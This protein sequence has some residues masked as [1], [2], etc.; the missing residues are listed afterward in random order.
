MTARHT[1]TGIGIDLTWH[2]FHAKPQPGAPVVIGLRPEHFAVNG[3][4][5]DG[6]AVRLSLPVRYGERT[7]S[8]ATAFL[9]AGDQLVAVRIEPS[10]MGRLRIGDAMSASFPSDKLSVFDARTGLRM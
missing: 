2:D 10:L 7:G 6:D 9:E 8:D 4:A 5:R 3:S 1:P